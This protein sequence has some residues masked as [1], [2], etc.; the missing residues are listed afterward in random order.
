[1]RRLKQRRQYHYRGGI[2][3]NETGGAIE[4]LVANCKYYIG[5]I[6]VTVI[7][8]CI[9]FT[10]VIFEGGSAKYSK[11][12]FILIMTMLEIYVNQHCALYRP[13]QYSV[14]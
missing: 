1:M 14:Y 11:T 6:C 2:D 3:E 10:V 7:A 5:Y 8:H 12:K 4:T 9:K 13:T